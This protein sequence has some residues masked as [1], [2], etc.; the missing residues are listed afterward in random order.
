MAMRAGP[1]NRSKELPQHGTA[2][3]PARPQRRPAR[4][5]TMQAVRFRKPKSVAVAEVPVPRLEAPTDVVLKVNRTAICG[6]D[7]HIYNGLFP[8][9]KPMTLGHEFVGEVVEAGPRVRRLKVG[10]RVLVPFPIACGACWSCSRGL[11]THCEASNPNQGPE[12]GMVKGKGGGL[13][14][15]TDPYGGYEGGQAEYVRVPY[16]DAGPRPIPDGVDDVQAVLLTDVFPTGWAANAWSQVGPADT[17]AIFGAGPVGIMAA[18]AANLMGARE[19]I[20]VDPLQ[21]RLDVARRAANVTAIPA[22]AED[23]VERIRE[24]TQG[25]GADVAIDAVGMEAERGL[26]GKANALVHG[27]RGAMEAL[28]SCL[29]AV[30]RGG[31]VSVV[32]VYGTTYDNFPLDQVFDKGLTVRAGQAPVHEHIDRLIGIVERGEVRLD[33][34][35]THEM[36]L[37]QA[38]EA[39]RLFNEKRDGCVKV[40]LRPG[41]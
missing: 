28:R 9:A 33:D 21:Y 2:R 27:Q 25:R 14:G 19:A 1:G 10:D 35:V 20:V 31:R 17:V 15:Y 36:P 7:L 37:A 26:L 6:S 41:G 30:R 38:P 16:A 22:R 8:Q 39:Y 3:S 12:G 4:G 29:N 11:P 18:K 32:G 34:I 24:L 23:P 5:R 40:V 13:F